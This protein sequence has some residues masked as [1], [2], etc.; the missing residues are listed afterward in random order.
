MKH[1]NTNITR[2]ALICAGAIMLSAC[3]TTRDNMTM[4]LQ[5]DSQQAGNSE[6]IQKKINRATEERLVSQLR[7]NVNNVQATF[8]LA[9]LRDANGRDRL[10]RMGYSQVVKAD[11]QET[12]AFEAMKSF[13]AARLEAINAKLALA[14]Q[15]PS[16]AYRF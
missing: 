10:A 14:S 7:E 15:P 5:R 3:N 9:K 16:N 13:A 8:E 6:Y 4:Q 11:T 2:L 12:E 1:I